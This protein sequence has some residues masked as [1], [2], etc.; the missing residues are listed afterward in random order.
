MRFFGV[1]ATLDLESETAHI[2]LLV[3]LHGG[4][5]QQESGLFNPHMIVQSADDNHQRVK[6]KCLR[7]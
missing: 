1:A 2:N 3:R 6:P 7:F 5:A 4:H